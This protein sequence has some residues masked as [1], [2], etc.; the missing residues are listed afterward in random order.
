MLAAALMFITDSPVL[1]T[2]LLYV[3]GVGLVIWY[4]YRVVR[5]ALA[6]YDGRP[7]S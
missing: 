5:G 3:A 4:I 1:G 7:V 2:L 6:L